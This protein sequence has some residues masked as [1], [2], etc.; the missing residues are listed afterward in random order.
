MMGFNKS[1]PVGIC[2]M[3][4]VFCCSVLASPF[5]LLANVQVKRA[6]FFFLFGSCKLRPLAV[7]RWPLCRGNRKSRQKKNK[8]LGTVL[9]TV[10]F[11]SGFYRTPAKVYAGSS[12]TSF[13][14]SASRLAQSPILTQRRACLS[15][16]FSFFSLHFSG[17]SWAKRSAEIRPELSCN[18]PQPDDL[19]S[20]VL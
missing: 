9:H 1:A 18:S 2:A 11:G 13:T 15:F 14:G 8:L 20:R 19:E 12:H 3:Y 4:C 5:I 7:I 17:C 6:R 10:G 16:P